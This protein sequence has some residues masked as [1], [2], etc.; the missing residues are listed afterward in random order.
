MLYI[1]IATPELL[2]SLTVTVMGSPPLDGLK[3]RVRVPAPGTRKSDAL[4]L[5]ERK[6]KYK[7]LLFQNN[8]LVVII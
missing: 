6:F 1:P 3:V 4:Y 7:V 8:F 5:K 2:N